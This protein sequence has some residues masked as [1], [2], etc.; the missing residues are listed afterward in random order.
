MKMRA[1][2][3]RTARGTRAHSSS[4][5]CSPYVRCSVDPIVSEWYE[6]KTTKQTLGQQQH[7]E[8]KKPANR[9]GRAAEAHED[10]RE[11]LSVLPPLGVRVI[12]MKHCKEAREA[13]L[14]EAVR[15]VL[16]RHRED[17]EM[18]ALVEAKSTSKQNKKNKKNKKKHKKEE[19]ASQ[20]ASQLALLPREI[21]ASLVDTLQDELE[22]LKVCA[23]TCLSAAFFLGLGGCSQVFTQLGLKMKKKKF[24]LQAEKLVEVALAAKLKFCGCDF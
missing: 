18:E 20:L 7:K 6:T 21:H 14:V 1:G 16:V 15:E 11:R 17:L 8:E 4:V 12:D 13:W 9:A 3:S 24:Q 19:R 5:R 23:T 10:T 2:I 22:E